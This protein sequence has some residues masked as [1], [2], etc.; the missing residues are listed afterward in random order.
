MPIFK[1]FSPA[2]G[3]SNNFRLYNRDRVLAKI[4]SGS[5]IGVGEQILKIS[6]SGI[7]V[8]DQILK[9]SR[10]GIGVGEQILKNRGR[11]SGSNKF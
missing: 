7:G 10:S 11:G 6:G 1:K 8:G 2:A 3:F 4:K 9:N 5:G